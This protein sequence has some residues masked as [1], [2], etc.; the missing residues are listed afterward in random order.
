MRSKG[1]F[2]V[3]CNSK[4]TNNRVKEKKWE[5]S[6]AMADRSSFASCCRVPDQINWVFDG[7]SL[8]RECGTRKSPLVAGR[9]DRQPEHAEVRIK[10]SR[11]YWDDNSECWCPLPYPSLSIS[12][13]FPFTLL[14]LTLYFIRFSSLRPTFLHPFGRPFTYSLLFAFP[15]CV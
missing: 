12:R 2:L 7:L 14:H 15:G 6:A 8:V 3:Q 11:R 5:K 4:V 1:Y 9:R 10:S 13:C